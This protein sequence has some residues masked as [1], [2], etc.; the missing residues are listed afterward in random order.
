MGYISD[1]N[2]QSQSYLMWLTEYEDKV[3]FEGFMRKSGI[4]HDVKSL[5]NRY[6]VDDTLVQLI[7]LFD[8]QSVDVIYPA[9]LAIRN[10]IKFDSSK[11]IIQRLVERRE[12]LNKF[13]NAICIDSGADIKQTAYSSLWY[14]CDSG[15]C[16]DDLMNNGLIITLIEKLTEPSNEYMQCLR[17]LRAITNGAD[18]ECIGYCIENGILDPLCS[19]IETGT[20]QGFDDGI[21]LAMQILQ[22]ILKEVGE[23]MWFDGKSVVHY[24]EEQG[25]VHTLH[26]LA[27]AG[28]GQISELAADLIFVHFQGVPVDVRTVQHVLAD[29]GL[30]QYANQFLEF[31]IK[32]S[33][34]EGLALGI[35]QVLIPDPEHLNIFLR[36]RDSIRS[37]QRNSNKWGNYNQGQGAT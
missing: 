35:L 33:M 14:I 18:G 17:T 30:L 31:G 29:L 23:S 11:R 37:D 19:M 10:V 25:T 15:I 22:D 28:A 13:H 36:W 34:L 4:P 26:E 32:Y 9:M 20:D 2:Y 6:F 8:H 24:I 5:C 27:I 1:L 3:L 7:E 21:L 16:T 12:I